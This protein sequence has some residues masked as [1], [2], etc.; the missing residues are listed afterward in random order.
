MCLRGGLDVR[1]WLEEGLLDYVT[2]LLYQAWVLDPN[3]PID[4]LIE[5][6]HEHD[7]SVYG[8]L[9]PW[10]Y[11]EDRVGRPIEHPTLESFRAA[12]ANYWARG[13]DGLYAW[14]LNWP[15]GEE[16]RTSLSEMADPDLIAES[17]KR[18]V[19]RRKEIQSTLTGYEASIPLRISS[20]QLGAVHKIPFFIADDTSGKRER[21]RRVSLKINISELVT[22]D[23]LTIKLNGQSLE[24]E[25]MT[26][27]FA[28]RI[29]PYS[30]QWL[31]IQLDKI[32]PVKGE[33][34]LEISLDERPPMLGGAIVIED[35]EVII[36]YG[37]YPSGL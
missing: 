28:S 18:Y 14:F 9:Q 15:F 22:A 20:D 36:K 25:S 23:R 37:T 26:R 32:R 30:G 24:T 34:S 12:S 10:Q 3:M 29:V 7:I 13:V 17:D 27:S 2:P 31:E 35:V 19:L 21:I 4:W 6:A 5:A 33:N 16:E 8:M 1:T 11:E